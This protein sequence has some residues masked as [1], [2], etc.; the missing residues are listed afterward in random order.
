MNLRVAFLG[1]RPT[2]D[3]FAARV[4]QDRGIVTE[5]FCSQQEALNWLAKWRVAHSRTA[6]TKTTICLTQTAP[7]KP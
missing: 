5:V 4:A 1:K 7:Q 3:G 2:T 6:R